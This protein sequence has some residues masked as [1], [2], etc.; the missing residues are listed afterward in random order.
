MYEEPQKDVKRPV[1]RGEEVCPLKYESFRRWT[2]SGRN[3][4]FRGVEEEVSLLPSV[5]RSGGSG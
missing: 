2:R 4:C 1:V 5:F 3:D